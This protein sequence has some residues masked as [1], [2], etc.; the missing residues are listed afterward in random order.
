MASPK[1]AVQNLLKGEI[2]VIDHLFPA[3][4]QR[5]SEMKGVRVASFPLPSV[6]MLVPCSD[7]KFLA[8]RNFRRALQYAIN[9]E[10]ILK[11][12]LLQNREIPGCRVISGPFPAGLDVS[13][14]LGYAYDEKITPRSYQPQVAMLLT[15]LAKKQMEKVAEKLKEKPPELQPIRLAVPNDALS[16]IA[17]EAIKSQW[18]VIGLKIETVLM[19]IGKTWPEEGTADIVYVA[20]AVWEPITDARRILGP[21]GLAK[22]KDQ[23]VGLG[24]RQLEQANNWR[25]VRDRLHELHAIA[26]NELPVIPLWQLIDSFAYREQLN[27]IGI[28]IVSLYQNVERWQLRF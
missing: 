11:G 15:V 6:H 19:P 26:S 25:D 4:A 17:C 9:R 21:D 5:L 18:E 28:N 7:H 10:D 16:Q 22:S 27:G 24:L 2:D 23:L 12:E 8:D 20:A 3:D 13:D 1:D 14:P